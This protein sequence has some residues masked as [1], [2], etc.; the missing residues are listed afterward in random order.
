MKEQYDAWVESIGPKP[1]TAPSGLTSGSRR[2]VHSVQPCPDRVGHK[3]WNSGTWLTP[4]EAKKMWTLA[5]PT[6]FNHADAISIRIPI[7]DADNELM[8]AGA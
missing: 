2:R 3:N 7:E 1:M 8:A 5:R 4:L 6:G